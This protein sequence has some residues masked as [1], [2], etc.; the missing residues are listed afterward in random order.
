MAQTL[1]VIEHFDP[2]GEEIVFRFPPQ[3]SAEIKMGAQLVVHETQ[4]AVL[5]R[6]GKALD[7]FG[8]GRHTLVTQ[9][10]PLLTKAIAMPFG[11]TSPFRVAVGLVNKTTFLYQKR[12]TTEPA[13]FRHPALGMA[14]L[15]PSGTTA[16][17]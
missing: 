12:G 13:L 5:F 4:E 10:V 16:H 6:D 11:G 1:E 8:P 15:L 7:V 14:T 2:S 9:T 17:P 3:G